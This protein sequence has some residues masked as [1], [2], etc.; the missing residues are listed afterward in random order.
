M[1]REMAPPLTTV[2]LPR[3]ELAAWPC[4]CCCSSLGGSGTQGVPACHSQI[5]T[6]LVIRQSR[7]LFMQT[8]PAGMG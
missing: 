7:L 3:H 1:A 6:H 5:A 2:A 8:A 4:V